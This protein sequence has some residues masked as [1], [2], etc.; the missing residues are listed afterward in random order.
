MWT[1]ISMLDSTSQPRIFIYV[2]TTD[3]GSDQAACRRSI[4]ACVR[5]IPNIG[6]ISID[7]QPHQVHLIA[8]HGLGVV[9]TCLQ[10]AGITWNYYSSLCKVTHIWRTEARN[11][12]STW[13]HAHGAES[14]EKF[15]ASLP[16]KCISGRWLSVSNTEQFITHVADHA[17]DVL[18][19]VLMKFEPAS[20][21][22]ERDVESGKVDADSTK[23]HQ[24][25]MGRWRRDVLAVI[26]DR[27]FWTVAE[28]SRRARAA[29]DHIHAFLQE[30]LKDTDSKGFHLRRL[31]CGRADAVI[32]EIE[33]EL[34]DDAHWWETRAAMLDASDHAWYLHMGSA[35]L[36]SYGAAFHRRCRKLTREYP[37][38]LLLMLKSPAD[39]ACELRK[40]IAKELINHLRDGL[41]SSEEGS[42]TD[43]MDATTLK[44]AFLYRDM[45]NAMCESGLLP[46]ALSDLLLILD[47]SAKVSVQE[48]EGINSMIG[49]IAHR[50]PNISLELL[51]ARITLKKALVYKNLRQRWKLVQ[52][53]VESLFCAL[54]DA[55]QRGDVPRIDSAG[56][57][58]QDDHYNRFKAPMPLAD[59]GPSVEML[60]QAAREEQ[61]ARGNLVD[62]TP[63]HH[64]AAPHVLHFMRVASTELAS[65]ALVFTGAHPRI[66]DLVYLCVE[67]HR[68]KCMLSHWRVTA[69]GVVELELPLVYAHSL[70]VFAKHVSTCDD[71]KVWIASVIFDQCSLRKASIGRGKHVF[72]MSPPRCRNTTRREPA[73]ATD[74]L[75]AGAPPITP[76]DVETLGAATMGS[77]VRL[78]ADEDNATSLEADVRRI[79]KHT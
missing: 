35:L 78:I 52:P 79:K 39:V 24:G 69:R 17:P 27:R 67:R 56:P 57:V 50:A 60:K 18:R 29:I 14:A 76:D 70:D 63:R 7:C 77:V 41:P 10:S 25:K 34:R 66:G 72:T 11:I 28:S 12:Y 45:L 73:A 44:I 55:V 3:C 30:D 37:A 8:G 46:D 54:G 1:D 61:Q 47:E 33:K 6:F 59:V 4:S 49:E 15:P 64:M 75:Q 42:R 51:S 23:A 43:A 13:K 22:D 19:A 62:T 53:H 9:N 16:P 58:L 36:L 31:V 38:R 5:N 26:S 68:Y 2:A 32:E 71:V 40:T 21:K 74:L 65:E 20:A 48:V